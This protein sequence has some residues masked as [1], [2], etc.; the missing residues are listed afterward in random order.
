MSFSWFH[1]WS[2]HTTIIN[3]SSNAL[4]QSS[5]PENLPHAT[6]LLCT[7]FSFSISLQPQIN[8]S[9]ICRYT[10]SRVFYQIN[11]INKTNNCNEGIKLGLERKEKAGMK[12][13]WMLNWQTRWMGRIGKGSIWRRRLFEP[14][15]CLKYKSFWKRWKIE[16]LNMIICVVYFL[17]DR[18]R[19]VLGLRVNLNAFGQFYSSN[20][21]SFWYNCS[22][23]FDIRFFFTEN[24]LSWL[25]MLA[26]NT[27]RMTSSLY[28]FLDGK[29]KRKFQLNENFKNIFTENSIEN[30]FS[31]N[32]YSLTIK[33][34]LIEIINWI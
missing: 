24:Y 26:K 29:F 10:N 14:K 30:C 12:H 23:S 13:R 1:H 3:L 6:P 15:H 33:L 34:K 9:F 8:H 31:G 25:R 32:S 4:W 11:H 17:F 7:L 28:G 21:I 22:D 18:N 19:S 20:N 27:C 5:I 2:H 16:G